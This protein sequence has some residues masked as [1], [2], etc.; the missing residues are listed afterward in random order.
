M[1]DSDHSGTKVS[2]ETTEVAVRPPAYLG[3]DVEEG[4]TDSGVYQ[5]TASGTGPDLKVPSTSVPSSPVVQMSHPYLA[6]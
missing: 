6:T 5:T 4:R 3:A 1:Q 2:W